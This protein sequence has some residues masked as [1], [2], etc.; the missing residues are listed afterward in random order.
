MREFRRRNLTPW[1]VLFW[2][3]APVLWVGVGVSGL[4]IVMSVIDATATDVR[5][6]GLRSAMLWW[7]AAGVTVLG[8]VG[9][10]LWRWRRKA[11]VAMAQR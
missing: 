1:R 8:A 6:H 5:L 10:R 7:D 9:V 11:V 3:Y 4:G 2:R